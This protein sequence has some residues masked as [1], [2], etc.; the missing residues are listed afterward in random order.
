MQAEDGD[1]EDDDQDDEDDSEH[2]IGTSRSGRSLGGGGGG[3]R[4]PPAKYSDAADEDSEDGISE[5]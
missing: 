4:A 2:P 5:G 3:R 1:N